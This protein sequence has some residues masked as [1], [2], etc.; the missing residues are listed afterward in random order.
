VTRSRRFGLSG[1]VA[2]H[3]VDLTTQARRRSESGTGRRV[4]PFREDHSAEGNLDMADL[5]GM[6]LWLWI[7]IAPLAYI[8]AVSFK[9]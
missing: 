3:R 8:L 2:D 5:A 6:A 1:L 7:I 9:K 4:A